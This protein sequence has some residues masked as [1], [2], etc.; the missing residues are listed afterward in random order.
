MLHTLQVK[1]FGHHICM[2][3]LTMINICVTIN[4]DPCV[5]IIK[6][7]L[8]LQYRHC[9]IK[10]FEYISTCWVSIITWHVFCNNPHFLEPAKEW[11]WILNMLYYTNVGYTFLLEYWGDASYTWSKQNCSSQLHDASWWLVHMYPY[12]Y[13]YMFVQE[14]PLWRWLHFTNKSCTNGVLRYEINWIFT[15]TTS[16]DENTSVVLL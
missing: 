12:K 14:T 5:L 8:Y 11:E 1:L 13:R 4:A 2:I 16:K 9:S 10:M 3:A 6:S 7:P 15:C